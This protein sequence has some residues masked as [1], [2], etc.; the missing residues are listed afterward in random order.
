MEK[1]LKGTAGVIISNLH[2]FTDEIL[3]LYGDNYLNFDARSFYS[4]FKK[5]NC[6]LLIG[7][8][9]KK[10]LSISGSVKFNH[11]I[12][13]SNL[14]EKNEKLKNI[15]GYCNAGV[16]LMKKDFLKKFN[17]G[18]FLD[19]NK[20][21]FK[22]KNFNKKCRVYKIKSCKAFDTPELNKKNLI[23]S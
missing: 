15:T 7:V 14:S 9:K 23:N 13:I 3:V 20:E 6:D 16:Y 21:I 10:D 4:Y 22:K 8:F 17:K 12:Q 5:N 1:K 19:F 18:I 2:L 11:L